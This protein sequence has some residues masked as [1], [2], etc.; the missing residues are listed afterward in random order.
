MLRRERHGAKEKKT[1]Q[2]V[3]RRACAQRQDLRHAHELVQ[4]RWDTKWSRV[5]LRALARPDGL[6]AGHRGLLPPAALGSA[7]F[8]LPSP[9]GRREIEGIVVVDATVTVA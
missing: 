5:Q 1:E 6:G 3:G 9:R 7:T 8:M 4:C 2:L